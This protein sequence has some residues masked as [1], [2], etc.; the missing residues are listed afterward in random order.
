MAILL[1]TKANAMHD[2]RDALLAEDPTLDIRLF[3]DAGDPKD[4]EAAVC[5]TQ[6]DMAELRRYPNLKLVV[7]M[8]AGVDHLLRPPGP[9]PGIPVARLKDERLTSGMTEWVLLNV[10]RFHRQD[11]E[12]RAQQAARIWD[13]LPAPDTAKRRIGMLGL[14]QLGNASAQALRGLGFPVMGWTRN[15]RQVEGVTCFSGPDGLEAMLRQTDILVCLLPLTPETRGVIN[16]KTLGFL[17]RGAFV[18]NAARGGHLVAED[19]LAALDSG[20]VAAAALDVFEPE[21][22]PAEHRFW[23]HPKVLVWPHA[24]A[25]TIPSSAAPQVVENL[26][27]AREG[28]PLINLVDFSA[29]Y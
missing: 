15:P 19:L 26:R 24:S 10:L 7:S 4:I 29:G 25:I 17:P 16:A 22:L 23:T 1:S 21:P 27:R 13:E 6:H 20:H 11:L 9:P 12:Y 18:I 3:P 28:R 2:W 14:G 5:W 8:G